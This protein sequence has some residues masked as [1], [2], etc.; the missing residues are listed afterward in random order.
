MRLSTRWGRPLR[1]CPWSANVHY[2]HGRSRG[3]VRHQVE[4]I[5]K[6]SNGSLHAHDLVF[7]AHMGKKTRH[8]P[9]QGIL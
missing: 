5:A 4:E 2:D 7:R 6:M 1:L 3:E 8:W 9:I